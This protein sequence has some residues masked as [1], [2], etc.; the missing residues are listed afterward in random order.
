MPFTY[1]L[2]AARFCQLDHFHPHR[3]IKAGI[4]RIVEGQLSILTETKG[5]QVGWVLS[6]QGSIFPKSPLNIFRSA[7]HQVKR[8]RFD[9]LETVLAQK[10]GKTRLGMLADV[11]SPPVIIETDSLTATYPDWDLVFV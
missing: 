7:G 3:V 9:S 5:H 8:A 1:L 11:L 10:E 4:G 6:Q 2:P